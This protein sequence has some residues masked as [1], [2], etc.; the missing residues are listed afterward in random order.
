LEGL[1]RRRCRRARTR[2]IARMGPGVLICKTA[3]GTCGADTSGH[4]VPHKAVIGLFINIS[5]KRSR[6][7]FVLITYL[8]YA[9]TVGQVR[10]QTFSQRKTVQILDVPFK[11]NIYEKANDCLVWYTVPISAYCPHGPRRAGMH[12]GAFQV[13]GGSA[14]VTDWNPFEIK[15][16]LLRI[17]PI[18][19]YQHGLSHVVP[20]DTTPDC[21][22]S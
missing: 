1:C 15:A 20:A 12:D 9:S 8:T 21:W 13:W 5:F 2:R 7:G 10:N 22:R 17:E 11:A 3:P 19:A 6:P 4:T 16:R 18:M 14:F